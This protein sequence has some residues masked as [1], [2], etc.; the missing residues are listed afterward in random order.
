MAT[1]WRY[2]CRKA[3]EGVNGIT[4]RCTGSSVAREDIKVTHSMIL[5]SSHTI[6]YNHFFEIKPLMSAYA[7]RPR[8]INA[9]HSSE[10]V[11]SGFSIES[12]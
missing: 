6:D 10:C 4:I 2:D 8:T 11:S 12:H 3:A 7:C 9:S 1:F 5:P